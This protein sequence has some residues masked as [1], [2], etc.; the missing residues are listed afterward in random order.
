MQVYWINRVLHLSNITFA[1]AHLLALKSGCYMTCTSLQ[2]RLNGYRLNG[3][4]LKCEYMY[5]S[6]YHIMQSWCMWKF[7]HVMKR[8]HTLLMMTCCIRHSLA[9]FAS[10]PRVTTTNQSFCSS[11]RWYD[12]VASSATIASTM[13]SRCATWWHQSPATASSV[14]DSINVTHIVSEHKLTASFSSTIDVRTAGDGNMQGQ[15]AVKVEMYKV[16]LCKLCTFQGCKDVTTLRF[17]SYIHV[18][19]Y[20]IVISTAH[21][22]EIISGDKTS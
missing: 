10:S 4:Y 5:T 22:P 21:P 7:T 8:T 15:R 3:V 9:S 16:A 2:H 17:K 13:T 14:D 6:S 19:K 20:T 18:C 12:M 1:V 11:M